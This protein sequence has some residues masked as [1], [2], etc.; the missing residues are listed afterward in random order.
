MLAWQMQMLLA[1]IFQCL[2]PLHVVCNGSFAQRRPEATA[3]RCCGRC[4]APVQ[5]CAAWVRR[6]RRLQKR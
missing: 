2:T 4:P 5:R 6:A 3:G 1:R